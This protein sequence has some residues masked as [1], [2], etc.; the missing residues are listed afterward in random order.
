MIKENL[1]NV[2]EQ[3]QS[4]VSTSP[5]HQDVTLLAVSKTHS[6]EDIM[7][8]YEEGQRDFGENKVQEL[9]QKADQLP[10]DIRWHMIGHL[11]T[12]KVRSVLPRACMIHSVDSLH[13]AEIIDK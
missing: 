3:I 10:S 9:I 11:Q 8:A 4:A 12:N 7:Q 1:K 13:L 2:R 5:Y 6:V